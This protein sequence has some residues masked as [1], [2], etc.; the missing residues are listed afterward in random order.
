MI[1]SDLRI[2]PVRGRVSAKMANMSF[3][4][5]LLI[6][7]FHATPAPHVGTIG[8]WMC[9]VLGREGMCMMAV[10]Y[11]FTASGYFLLGG[12]QGVDCESVKMWWRRS[13]L[14]RVRSLIIPFYLWL[15]IKLV[16]DLGVWFVKTSVLHVRAEAYPLNLPVPELILKFLGLHPFADVGVVWYLRCLFLLVLISPLLVALLKRWRITFLI[17]T[18]MYISFELTYAV[19]RD[20]NFYH[21]FD[22]ILSFRGLVYFFMGM[23]LRMKGFDLLEFTLNRQLVWML[24]LSV[25]GFAL[26]AFATCLNMPFCSAAIA[27]TSVPMAIVGLFALMPDKPFP[28]WANSNSFALYLAHNE[29]LSVASMLLV[30]IGLREGNALGVFVIRM[31]F[32]VVG[33]IAFAIMVKRFLP[34]AA[35]ILFGG[36]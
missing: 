30:I 5:A 19:W 34:K 26:A 8:W 6:V 32:G 7:A 11:F 18:F 22:R 14:S 27:V 12:L 33:A 15:L 28:R 23:V 4:C 24:V 10:P 16:F 17:L 3:V 31:M 20:W 1:A 29:F 2:I 25:A 21:V 9:H 35:V 13:V 36:R